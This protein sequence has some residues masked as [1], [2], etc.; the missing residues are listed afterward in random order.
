MNGCTAAFFQIGRK[1]NTSSFII[2]TSTLLLTLSTFPKVVFYPG[3]SSFFMARTGAGEKKMAATRRMAAVVIASGLLVL[4]FACA[5]QQGRS[6]SS[7]EA[8]EALPPGPTG[9]I[10]GYISDADGN[11]VMGA[12][13]KLSHAGFSRHWTTQA[14]SDGKYSFSGVP[15]VDGYSMTV[16]TP[17]FWV[18]TLRDLAVRPDAVTEVNVT[19][20]LTQHPGPL[21]PGTPGA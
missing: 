17:P 10:A 7:G 11:P 21:T 5:A 19:R 20:R 13:V 12:R 15:A 8:V 16:S 14:D 2:H 4:L 1:Y 18:T 6:P 3:G 9:G